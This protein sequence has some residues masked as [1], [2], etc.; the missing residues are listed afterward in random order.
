MGY[1]IWFQQYIWFWCYRI[2]L[3]LHKLEEED[4][5]C[6]RFLYIRCH[7][8]DWRLFHFNI[9]EYT[10]GALNVLCIFIY[11]TW[12]MA[13]DSNSMFG[14]KVTA[15]IWI[16]TSLMKMTDD[17]TEFHRL[18]KFIWIWIQMLLV[19][20]NGMLKFLYYIIYIKLLSMKL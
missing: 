3:D 4:F 11:W 8:G 7:P 14:F 1:G 10:L 19:C 13:F 15:F 16:C 2:Y 12:D 18:L 5:W 20:N 9:F 6:I 17:V